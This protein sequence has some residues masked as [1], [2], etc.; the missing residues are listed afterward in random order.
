MTTV[1]GHSTY[2]TGQPEFDGKTYD[3]VLDKARLSRQL[4]AVKDLMR[5]GEWRSLGEIAAATGCPEASVS[6]RLRDLRKLKFGGHIVERRRLSE[7]LHEYR[8]LLQ[9]MLTFEVN[10]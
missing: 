1:L 8:L 6:A 9:L 2:I 10:D 7:G 4:D 5:D 3:P